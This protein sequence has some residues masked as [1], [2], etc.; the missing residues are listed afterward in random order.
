MN[1]MTVNASSLLSLLGR[2]S[3]AES[4]SSSTSSYVCNT[5]REALQKLVDNGIKVESY[6]VNIDCD[7]VFY[8]EGGVE[9][10]NYTHM[11]QLLRLS[12]SRNTNVSAPKSIATIA[13]T[14]RPAEVLEDL[15]DIGPIHQH[16]GLMS[17][18]MKN[19]LKGG[20][21]ASAHATPSV[22]NIHEEG[23]PKFS[24][25]SAVGALNNPE[26]TTRIGGGFNSNVGVIDRDPCA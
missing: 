10:G 23:P 12:E 16:K 22:D 14:E 2:S 1:Q 13:K 25:K 19:A 17:S 26:G 3:I 24:I 6:N 11:T 15:D 18:M 7:T 9:I 21:Q 4:V 8:N 5:P 20:G